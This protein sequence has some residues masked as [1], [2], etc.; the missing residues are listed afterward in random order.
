MKKKSE[1]PKKRKKQKSSCRNSGCECE[2]LQNLVKKLEQS[3]NDQKN[4]IEYIRKEL[5]NKAVDAGRAQL[6]AML[7]HNIGNA[8]TPISMYTEKLKNGNQAQAYQYLTQCYNDLMEHKEHLTEYISTDER[9]IEVAKYMCALIN[10]LETDNSKTA[11]IID[12]IISG[13]DYVSQILSLQRSYSPGKN[14]IREKIN[15]SI[16]VLDALKIQEI[17]ISKRNIILKKNLP[18]TI[19]G[20]L[21]EKNKLMQVIINIIKNSLDAIDE[22][23]DKTDHKLEITTC[24][25]S[26]NIGLKIKDTGIGVEKERQKEIF[27]LGNSSKGSSGFGLY[28]CKN[29]IEANKGSLILESPGR[30]HGSTVT[31]EIPYFSGDDRKS[32]SEKM[33]T[34]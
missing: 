12:K 26:T 2:N 8:I 3:L 4:E 19:P 7:M 18:Q 27:D 10:N 22:H 21:M 30:G 24:C 13:I 20:I 16:M 9:G 5:L 17:S 31:I 28:Y 25:D 11:N 33:E 23:K 34:E 1:N 6:S 15:M 14:E 29:F 32:G